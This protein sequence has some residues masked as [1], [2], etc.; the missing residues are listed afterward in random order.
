MTRHTVHLPVAA[1]E[2]LGDFT[3]IAERAEALGYDRVW[4][5]ET[6]GRDAATTLAAIAD[7]TESIGIGTS[8]VN[9]YSRSPAL[10]GQTAATLQEHSEGRFRLGMGPSGP[11]V[12]QGWH[13][14]EFSRPLRR[15]REYVEIV[16]QVLSGEQ[17]DYDGDMI[18]T[19]GFR[20]RQDPP[21]PAPDIDVTGM[22]PKAV[23]LAG[24]FA[25]GWHA[26]M[27]TE[28]G[29]RD[30]LDDLRRGADLG[31]RD[32]DEVQTTF[33]L[34]CCALPD[35]DAARDLTRQHL[36]FY[37]GGM[38]DFYRDALARQGHEDAAVAIHDAWQD[39]DHERAVGLVD[40]DLL[41]ALAA[42]GTPDEV[43]Q[44]FDEFAAIEGVD[45]VAVSF[46]RAADP[47]VIDATLQA[48][49]PDA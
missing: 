29:I 40:D 4:F 37:V 31:D 30:R 36:A 47:D 11:A 18:Q 38:G 1:Q 28:D 7:N 5:P 16:R 13:G 43:R 10:V 46:P 15:T 6:W 24:R 3:D 41:D 27:F 19:R 49:A 14:E 20:L 12:I 22:G 21:E 17:V 26:L 39:G 33:V 23:E 9:T 48:V 44:R 32:A 34:P 35:G 2:S 8:I 25:D 45:A 42:A